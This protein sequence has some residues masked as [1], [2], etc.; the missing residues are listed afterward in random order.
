MNSH[1]SIIFTNFWWHFVCPLNVCARATVNYLQKKKINNWNFCPRIHCVQVISKIKCLICAVLVAYQIQ[2]CS[3]LTGVCP[4]AG[5][6]EIRNSNERSHVDVVHVCIFCCC[7]FFCSSNLLLHHHHPAS[8][9][10]SSPSAHQAHIYRVENTSWRTGYFSKH[11][12]TEAE[13]EKR[14]RGELA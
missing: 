8:S 5:A 4:G 3:N 7:F 9:S 11:I 2:F 10:S 14:A 1:R 13:R 6:S 12:H